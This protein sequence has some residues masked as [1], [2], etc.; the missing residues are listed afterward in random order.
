[1]GALTNTK[2]DGYVRDFPSDLAST[3]STQLRQ[4][5]CL[6]QY[7]FCSMSLAN[8]PLNASKAMS[9]QLT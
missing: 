9:Q 7:V 2:L 6:H 8:S 4:L 3:I 1:M 5:Q